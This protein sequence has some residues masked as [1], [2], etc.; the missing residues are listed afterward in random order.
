VIGDD[1]LLRYGN[2]LCVPNI[3]DPMRKLMVEA[4]QTVYTVHA[5]STKVYKVLKLCYW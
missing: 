2:R 1:D 5:G 4:Y 3:D